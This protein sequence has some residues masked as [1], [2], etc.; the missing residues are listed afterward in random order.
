MKKHNIQEIQLKY[1]NLTFDAPVIIRNSYT[2]YEALMNVFDKDQLPIREE[3]VVLFL[4]RA[5]HV[6]GS[7]QG[8]KG[9]ITGVSVDIRI[10]FSIA[11]KCLAVGIIVSHNHPSGQLVP[12]KEDKSITAN[13]KQSGKLLNIELLD[14]III[15]AM[16]E[17]K[18]FADEGWL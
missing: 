9:G 17:Y 8:F 13:I 6:I 3:F 14:H 5:N 10:I 4:N 12:S 11:L 1:P 2:A 7:Y 15:N 16:G 18:S